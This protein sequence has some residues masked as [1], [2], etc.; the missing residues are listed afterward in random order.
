M[1]VDERF[2]SLIQTV[3]AGVGRADGWTPILE[4]LTEVTGA[5]SGCIVV[6]DGRDSRGNVD[7]FF[8]IDPDWIDAYN[9]HYFKYDP[10]PGVMHA[11]P[12]Q[13]Q[14][15]HV[16][17]PRPAETGGGS[18]IFYHEVMVPQEFRHTLSLGL[19]GEQGWQAGIILQRTPG[20]GAFASEAV[21]ALERLSP[22]LHQGL[23]LHARIAHAGGLQTGMAAALDNAPVGVLLLDANGRAVHAN[24]SA[25]DLLRKSDAL[26]VNDE[27]LKALHPADHKELQRLVHVA[28]GAAR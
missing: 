26:S 8:N 27:G 2:S 4:A 24:Q 15:D 16:T 23:Q 14:V 5:V 28:L 7:C 10:S 9:A 19:S 1:A 17:G 25:E 3:Y 11:R 12:G 21:A 22:H 18:R 13:V 20:Q 6:A